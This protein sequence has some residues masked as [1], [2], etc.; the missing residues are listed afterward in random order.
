MPDLSE[1][2]R[3]AS[4]ELPNPFILTLGFPLLYLHGKSVPFKSVKGSTM[5]IFPGPNSSPPG[6]RFFTRL[7]RGSVLAVS[8]LVATVFPLWAGSED[9]KEDPG[10]NV[11]ALEAAIAQLDRGDKEGLSIIQ[12]LADQGDPT[13]QEALLKL[14]LNPQAG[15]RNPEKAFEYGSKAYGFWRSQ[16]TPPPDKEF[17]E[18]MAAGKQKDLKTAVE[19]ISASAER[20][21]GD[22]CFQLSKQHMKGLGVEKDPEKA[23]KYMLKA[24]EYIGKCIRALRDDARKKAC[25][26]NMRVIQGAIELYNMDHTDK[27]ITQLDPA[28]IGP[29]GMLITEKYLK[30]AIPKPDPQCSYSSEGD[31]T[32]DGVIR[33][34]FHGT[35][36]EAVAKKV[37]LPVTMNPREGMGKV[38]AEKNCMVN[39]RI[40]QA[41]IEMYNMDHEQM[42]TSYDEAMGAA[43]GIL[44]TGHYLKGPVK[45]PDPG[46]RYES[47]G[48]LSKSGLLRCTL[49]GSPK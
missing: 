30:A 14:F 6:F 37:E 38:S 32:G 15:F 2:K 11:Q 33:C 26:A 31:L 19:K 36:D 29:D 25:C 42:I 3:I 10:K 24:M 1:S 43:D 46:C 5:K 9:F 48:D 39:L 40:L 13:A 4:R 45:K 35:V 28:A 7:L 44:V 47:D 16:L 27:M 22:A 41:A 49:H 20:G 23:G 8:F 21:Y 17:E 18:G 34:G 12:G